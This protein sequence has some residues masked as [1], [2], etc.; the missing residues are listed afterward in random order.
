[1]DKNLK[2]ILQMDLTPSTS[3]KEVKS[4]RYKVLIN[5]I[6]SFV[7]T[8][9]FMLC[10]LFDMAYIDEIFP[11]KQPSKNEPVSYEMTLSN[12]GEITIDLDRTFFVVT[13]GERNFNYIIILKVS[14]VL[15][16]GA[17]VFVAVFYKLMDSIAVKLRK[18]KEVAAL[19]ADGEF[20]EKIDI[21]GD[22][23]LAD[24]ADNI[25]KI[26]AKF[27]VILENEREMERTKNELITSIAHDLRTPV[28]SI[29]GYMDLIES[30]ELDEETRKKY[31]RIVCDKSERLEKLI[32]DLFTYT[33][34]SLG[35]YSVHYSQLNIGK[36]MEQLIEEFYPQFME[37]DLN[38][39]FTCD[40]PNLMMEG[41]GELLARLFA[42]LLSNSVKY[43]R[44]GKTLEVMVEDKGEK[45]CVKVINYG[46][47]IPKNELDR[48]FNKFYRLESSRNSSTGG[49]GL[50]LAIVKQIVDIH[51]GE[52]T[53]DSSING[54]VFKVLLPI[55]NS[56][57]ELD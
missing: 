39:E 16:S 32:E 10:V 13:N 24:I 19:I 8:I 28:T 55:N 20:E 47:V 7:F 45:V 29:M 51:K 41:D 57:K 40:N 21:K 12:N 44:D 1:M 17:I 3:K 56:D 9:F 27:N 5:V 43:G 18:M 4:I 49:T 38:C 25:N 33:K 15:I 50:G 30:K 31:I 46:N 36:L 42:N 6:I 2:E 26:T 53:V 23:E 48:I 54:T 52:I 11:D 37:V 14:F 22:D 34:F 35:E